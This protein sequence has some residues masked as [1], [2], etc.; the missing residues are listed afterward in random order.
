MAR[1]QARSSVT[2]TIALTFLAI[3]LPPVF[4]LQL[5]LILH[6]AA[7]LINLKTRPNDVTLLLK[8]Q[9]KL[10][11]NSAVVLHCIH[12]RPARVPAKT[13]LPP[14]NPHSSSTCVLDAYHV[15]SSLHLYSSEGDTSM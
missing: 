1:F 14:P 11:N 5:Q 3:S 13:Y 7:H 10:Q 15:L 4:P 6:A 12:D 8:Q 9:T 2:W